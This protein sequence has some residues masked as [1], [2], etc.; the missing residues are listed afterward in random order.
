MEFAWLDAWLLD[1]RDAVER[2]ILAAK[3][4]IDTDKLAKLSKVECDADSTY[5]WIFVG[6]TIRYVVRKRDG[7]ILG[8][9]NGRVNGHRPYG[10]VGQ[11]EAY[12]WGTYP[13][14]HRGTRP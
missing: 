3:P 8:F 10:V 1:L 5:E 4:N 12:D 11:W 6:G 14:E 9:E 7:V 2:S 13:P